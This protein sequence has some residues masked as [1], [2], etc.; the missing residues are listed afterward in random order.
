M[1]ILDI[2]RETDFSHIN[3]FSA[4]YLDKSEKERG[5]IFASRKSDP[6]ALKNKQTPDAVV[7]VPYHVDED[8]L[9]MIREFRVPLGETQYGFPAGLVDGE[10]TIEATAT[11]ELHEETGL[12]I[13][14][15]NQ[16]SP[17]IYSSSGLTDEALVLVYVDCAGI[18]TSLH[19]ND[20]E[21]IEVVMLSQSQARRLKAHPDACFDVKSWLIMNTFAE[22]GQIFA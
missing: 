7:V 11:R 9:V 14:R 22:T 17:I 20:S 6:A 1:R 2:R 3:L 15:L 8:K 21:D 10:E 4:T 18:P 16:L 12:T 19:T 5:W 13:V